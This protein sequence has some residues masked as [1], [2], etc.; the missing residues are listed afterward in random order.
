MLLSKV[1]SGIELLEDKLPFMEIENVTANTALI[2]KKTLFFLLRGKSFDREKILA[3]IILKKPAAIIADTKEK[4]ISDLPIIYVKNVRKAYSHALWNIN[5][6]DADKL[7]FYAVTGTNGKTTT[8]TMLYNIF[9][10]AKIKCA[11]IGTG[12]IMIGK[13]IISEPY[14]SMTTPDPEILYPSIKRME[15][16]GCEKIVMEVSSHALALFKVSPILFECS[17][18]TNLSEEHLDFHKNIDDYRECKLSLFKQSKCGIFNTDDSHI[19]KCIPDFYKYIDVYTVGIKNNADAIAKD[20]N[21]KGFCGASYVYRES[22][23]IFEID[24]CY[25]GIYNISNSLLAAKCALLCGIDSKIIRS[26]FLKEKAIDGRFEIVFEKP[27]VI[28][29]YAHTYIAF[30]NI[31]EL[32]KKAKKQEQKI[33]TVFGCGGE[34]DKYKRPKMAKISENFSDFSIVTT[35]NSRGESPKKI[36]SDITDGFVK[37]ESYTVIE[38]RAEAIGYAIKIAN[39]EDVVLIIGKGHERYNIDSEGYHSFDEREIIKN[40]LKEK[41]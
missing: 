37:K 18:F 28:I 22:N 30:E 36:I 16:E 1:L 25:P 5:E 3:D 41:K 40:A 8:A 6:I 4:G 14:Y 35:D 38:N 17:M 19:K 12:K 7:K 39:E 32:V 10:E 9:S 29:D 31:L 33:I 20:I 26:S 23:T 24:L 34:R 11:F 15:K 13:E 2:G 21:L 27:T